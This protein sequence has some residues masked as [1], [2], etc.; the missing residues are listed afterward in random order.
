MDRS[1]EVIVESEMVLPGYLTTANT[2]NTLSSD[3]RIHHYTQ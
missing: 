2:P 3:A 1:T